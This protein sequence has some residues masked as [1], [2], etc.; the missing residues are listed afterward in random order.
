MLHCITIHIYKN[1]PVT[2]NHIHS[3]AITIKQLCSLCNQWKSHSSIQSV[4]K[5]KVGDLQSFDE[6]VLFL[7]DMWAFEL[8]RA[9]LEDTEI[10]QEW[11]ILCDE[12]N[13]L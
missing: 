13:V 8:A 7:L 9:H 2:I 12:V 11:K 3:Y 5:E 6:T 1:E 4:L 10:G